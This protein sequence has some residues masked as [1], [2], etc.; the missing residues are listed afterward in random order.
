MSQPDPRSPKPPS[1]MIQRIAELTEDVANLKNTHRVK[2]QR[3]NQ[4]EAALERYRYCRHGFGLDCICTE[5]ARNALVD[6]P[7]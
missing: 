6:R 5:A 4:L 1:E 3:V 2:D 7:L